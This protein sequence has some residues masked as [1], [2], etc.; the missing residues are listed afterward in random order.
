MGNCKACIAYTHQPLDSNP[1]KLTFEAEFKNNHKLLS[2]M[3]GAF[4][5]ACGKVSRFGPF[6]SGQTA[7]LS[8]LGKTCG[9]VWKV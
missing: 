7:G 6:E 9:K 3:D 1:M 2:P 8:C 4:G 5:K